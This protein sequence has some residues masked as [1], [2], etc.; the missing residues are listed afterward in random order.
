[1]Q[2][3]QGSDRLGQCNARCTTCNAASIFKAHHDVI[4]LLEGLSQQVALFLLRFCLLLLQSLPLSLRCD[5]TFT[6]RPI[7]LLPLRQLYPLL[8][9]LG[10]RSAALFVNHKPNHNGRHNGDHDQDRGA[11]LAG[12]CCGAADLALVHGNECHE[13][14]RH[15]HS[16]ERMAAAVSQW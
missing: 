6:L 8:L 2:S 16:I 4:K 5:I 10:C 11:I 1:M 14:S 12:Y 7:N 13:V 3:L 15:G 9:C